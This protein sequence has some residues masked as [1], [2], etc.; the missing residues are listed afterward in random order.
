MLVAAF[1]TLGQVKQSMVPQTV[2]FPSGRLR[3]KAYL[4]KPS[5]PRP[6]PAVAL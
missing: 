5:G 2:E 3:L 1:A 4:W 6:F